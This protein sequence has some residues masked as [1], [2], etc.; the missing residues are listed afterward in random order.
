WKRGL[1]LIPQLGRLVAEVPF[2]VLVAR[3]E[4]PLLGTRAL[5]IRPDAED[6]AAIPFL[7]DELLE[8]VGLERR[9]AGHATFRV[10]HAGGKRV[11]VLSDHEIEPPF[12]GETVPI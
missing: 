4:V 2:T 6:D 7:L 10:V 12:P 5:F 8:R 1:E 9:A 3:R 11:L